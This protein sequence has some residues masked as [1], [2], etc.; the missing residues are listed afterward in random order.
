MEEFIQEKQCTII[1]N[2]EEENFVS[3]LMNV[4]RNI[5]T[6]SILDKESLE[7]IV[8]KYVRIFKSIW[9]KF[10]QYINITKY[11]KAW[12]NEKCHDKLTR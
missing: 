9:Y 1:R 2:S 7:T 6:S 8:Q 11:S 5:D 3:E 4:I 12:W 10:S